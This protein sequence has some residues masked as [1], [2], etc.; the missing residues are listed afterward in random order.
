MQPQPSQTEQRR[1]IRSKLTK[2]IFHF[3]AYSNT[4][5]SLYTRASQSCSV[6][7]SNGGGSKRMALQ[8]KKLDE[9]LGKTQQYEE[10]TR[11]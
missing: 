3:P 2:H 7:G 5:R 9:K 8:S 6:I 10:G 4:T 11:S 1:F